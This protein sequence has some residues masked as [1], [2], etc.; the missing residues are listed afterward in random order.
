MVRISTCEGVRVELHPKGERRQTLWRARKN[1]LAGGKAVVYSVLYLVPGISKNSS[2]LV[3]AVFSP[4]VYNLWW[5]NIEMTAPQKSHFYFNLLCQ[6]FCLFRIVNFFFNYHV[7]PRPLWGLI[8]TA[9][10]SSPRHCQSTECIP[11]APDFV[12]HQYTTGISQAFNSIES[13][14][15]YKLL[16][17]TVNFIRYPQD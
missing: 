1:I 16:S 6:Y 13:F 4:A 7:L 9:V 12:I 10:Q 17:V 3:D 11:C 15:W 8:R 2:I 5:K 14:S